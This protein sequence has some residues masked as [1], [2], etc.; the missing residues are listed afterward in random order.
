MARIADYVIVSDGKVSMRIGG[1]IDKEFTFNMPANLHRGS[2]SILAC[3]LDTV[4]P[5]D[6]KF[7]IQINGSQ[8][9]NAR[10]NSDVFHTVHEVIPA[11]LLNVNNNQLKITVTGGGGELQVGDITILSQVEV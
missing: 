9:F 2:R 3:M 5:D 6:L 4:D 8:V 7:K 11:D 10:Y 1:D